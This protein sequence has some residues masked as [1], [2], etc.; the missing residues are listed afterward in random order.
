M[1]NSSSGGRAGRF[2]VSDGLSSIVP[3]RRSGTRE[4]DGVSA[5]WERSIQF[6]IR[7]YRW[8]LGG[9]SSWCRRWRGGSAKVSEPQGIGNDHLGTGGVSIDADID[10]SFVE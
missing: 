7:D 9:C 10:P 8:R 3:R 1:A 4:D 5:I 6:P 2:E